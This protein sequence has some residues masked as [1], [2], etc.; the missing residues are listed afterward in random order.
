MVQLLL[1]I[2]L[3]PELATK[4]NKSKCYDLCTSGGV[5]EILFSATDLGGCP[6]EGSLKIEHVYIHVR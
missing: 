5:E 2:F 3:L 6:H 4:I 1:F